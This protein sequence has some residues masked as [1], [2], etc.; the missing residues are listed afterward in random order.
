MMV[1]VQSCKRC[2]RCVACRGEVCG[3][4]P[5][6]P[7]LQPMQQIIHFQ[8]QRIYNK[9]RLHQ[10]EIALDSLPLATG[11]QQADRR[12]RLPSHPLLSECSVVLALRKWEAAVSPLD[13]KWIWECAISAN[14][15]FIIREQTVSSEPVQSIIA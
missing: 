13:H 15:S 7:C 5:G 11:E 10:K 2:C 9:K 6:Y 8:Q 3:V 1:R 4:F 12:R 14:N